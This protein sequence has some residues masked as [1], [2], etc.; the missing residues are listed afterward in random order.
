MKIFT[1]RGTLFTALLCSLAVSHASDSAVNLKKN[2]FKRPDFL[3]SGS[4]E[5]AIIT[6]DGPGSELDVRAV[7]SAGKD[8]LVNIDGIIIRI[9]E[10]IHGYRLLKVEENKITLSKKGAIVTINVKT[11]AG[12][13]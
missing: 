1:F 12:S 2:P 11:G 13:N 6:N 5:T 3:N 8:S 4:N 10:E 9:G 7:M